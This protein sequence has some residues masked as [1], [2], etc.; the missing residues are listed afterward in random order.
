VSTGPQLVPS[1]A[2][3]NE[4]EE[5]NWVPMAIAA[6]VVVV[7]AT[8]AVLVLE[9][10]KSRA[11]V[12]PISATPDA[13]A[14]SLPIT[15]LAMS[16]SSNLAGGKVTYL[17]GHIANSGGRTVTG[18]SVQV[19]FRTF[20]HEVAQNETQQLKLIR[21]RQPYVDLEPVS[22]APLAPG[23][24]GDFRLIFDTVNPDWDG[25]YPEL[26]IVHVDTK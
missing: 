4:P 2:R 11:K 23:A 13:Y 20:A 12:T 18:V 3:P 25:A 21:T 7:V 22:A 1:A 16:E 14:A 8:I 9:H 10:G 6:A 15:G 19:L 5:R 24:E 17:D 26:R